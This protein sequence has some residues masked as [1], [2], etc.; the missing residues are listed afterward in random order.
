VITVPAWLRLRLPQLNLGRIAVVAI[1]AYSV[2]V[3]AGRPQVRLAWPDL[4]P[5]PA[6]P[7]PAKPASEYESLGRAYRAVLPRT[8]GAAWIKA[9]DQLEA[10]VAMG[11]I[12]AD[13]QAEWQDAR[14][15]AFGTAVQPA[16]ARLL[17]EGTEPTDAQ[18]S[19]LA[20]A[21]REFARGLKGGN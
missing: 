2:W 6:P 15:G 10:K 20:R 9:A 4:R 7:E 18:R 14:E 12:Q 17:P 21:W 11:K 19:P 5:L 16:F 8:Y 13:L 1:L 3:H